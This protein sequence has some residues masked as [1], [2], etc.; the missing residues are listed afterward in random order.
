MGEEFMGLI[1]AAMNSLA[2]DQRGSGRQRALNC[3]RLGD[4]TAVSA[5]ADRANATRSRVG[6]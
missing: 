5:A 4:A 2:E 1:Q 6:G 3:K